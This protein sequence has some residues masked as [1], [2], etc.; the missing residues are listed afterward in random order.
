[1][2]GYDIHHRSI[3]VERL[4]FH[5]PD[6]KYVT[7]RETDNLKNVCERAEK[8]RSKLEAF[9]ELCQTDIDALQ[10][11]YQEIPRHY[12][13]NSDI[14][15]WTKR[16]KGIQIGRMYNSHHGAGELW[17]L[18]MCL[19]RV[20]GPKSY[21]ELRTVEGIT[22]DTFRDACAAMGL[23]T[24]DNEYHEAFRENESTAFPP[25]LRE[26]FVHIIINCNVSDVR[27][28]WEEHWI[29]MSDDITRKQ[30][31]ITRL[32]SLI[33]TEEDLRNYTLAGTLFFKLNESR[34]IML[35]ANIILLCLIRS[36]LYQKLRDF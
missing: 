27:K 6:Q 21:K 32:D 17:Y 31:E 30:R 15:M 10:Y 13:W 12:V 35:I 4:S 18:R 23:L 28:L 33:L 2:F 9:F 7:F 29:P 36:F 20:R 8:K 25:Q 16:K 11:T 5:L 3:S 34:N 19:T 22:Y 14:C 26:M 1:M 24:D